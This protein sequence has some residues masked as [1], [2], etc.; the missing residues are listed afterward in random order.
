MPCF[1]K[2]GSLTADDRKF[3]LWEGKKILVTSSKQK[4]KAQ[5][6]NQRA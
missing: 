2:M 3:M 5:L 6:F 4:N 1:S